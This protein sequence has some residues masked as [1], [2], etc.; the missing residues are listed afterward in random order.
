MSTMYSTTPLQRDLEDLRG[1]LLRLDA[2]A[3][4]PRVRVRPAAPTPPSATAA[5]GQRG[6]RRPDRWARSA[7][8]D[9]PRGP[10]PAGGAGVDSAGPAGAR[11]L[12]WRAPQVAAAGLTADVLTTQVGLP[13]AGLVGLAVAA[14]V[15]WRLRF[16]PPSRP[17]P[18]TAAPTASGTPPACSAGST[19]T[20]SW[21]STTLQ[22]PGIPARTSTT[23]LS[24]PRACSSSTPSSDR[25]R[26]PGRRRACL[27]QPLPTG[28]HPGDGPLGSRDDEPAA[29]HPH[30]RTAVR[31]RRP[32]PRRPGWTPRAWQSCP[33]TCSA[34]RSALTTCFPT[35]MWSCSPPPPGPA[36][37]R[38]PDRA[39]P[40][41]ATGQQR[42]G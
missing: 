7:A 32:R 3:E 5:T 20:A 27:A 39:Q 6:P 13:Q 38:P 42:A 21:Y 10:P 25:Q 37:A 35:P 29:R 26:P 18:G 19:G 11:T 40:A 4:P 41:S 17:A 23:W 31:P 22:C 36:S 34:V 15:G 14:L 1:F 24:A 16:R 9:R 28:P 12:A 2:R 30:G 8:A 33:P